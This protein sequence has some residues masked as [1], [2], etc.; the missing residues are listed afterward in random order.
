[1]KVENS[2][3]LKMVL[4]VF[5][6][7]GRKNL[8]LCSSMSL[9]YF[10]GCNQLRTTWL[11][12]PICTV[13]KFF[14]KSFHA[15]LW[16]PFFLK[17]SPSIFWESFTCMN[18]IIWPQWPLARLNRKSSP[19]FYI[20]HHSAQSKMYTGGRFFWLSTQGPCFNNFISW[21]HTY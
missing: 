6:W 20:W 8:K 13:S 9:R 5:V 21:I 10:T 12:M 7:R 15:F 18:S 17:K 4:V 2:T 3:I 19:Y 14:K 1:M 16:Y 11:Q